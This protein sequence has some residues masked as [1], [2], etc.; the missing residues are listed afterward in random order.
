MGWSMHL[1]VLRS[2]IHV[3]ECVKCEV[4]GCTLGNDLIQV[5]LISKILRQRLFT[6]TVPEYVQMKAF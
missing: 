3:D 6:D 5:E 2:L 1:H 4:D